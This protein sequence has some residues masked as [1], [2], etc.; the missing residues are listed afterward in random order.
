VRRNEVYV[1][2]NKLFD[3]FNELNEDDQYDVT[4][5]FEVPIGANIRRRVCR[6]N[7]LS[8]LKAQ[9]RL[10][11]ADLAENPEFLKRSVEYADAQKEYDAASE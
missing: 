4:C 6:A 3:M 2:E 10:M 8:A 1:A 9:A 5:I 7:Y 11:A